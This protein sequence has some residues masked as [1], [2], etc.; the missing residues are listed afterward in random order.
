MVYLIMSSG[1]ALATSCSVHAMVSQQ[2]FTSSP[3]NRNVFIIVLDWLYTLFDSSD[4]TDIAN[5]F[6]IMREYIKYSA[7]DRSI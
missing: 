4:T 6:L 1:W 7:F 3:K 5:K 2:T